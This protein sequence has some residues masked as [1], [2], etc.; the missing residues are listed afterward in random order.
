MTTAG[1]PHPLSQ[2]SEDD[3]VM[4]LTANGPVIRRIALTTAAA[5]AASGLAAIGAA[6]AAAATGPTTAADKALFAYAKCMR[7][8]GVK[9]PDP[10]KGKDGKFA[11]PAI[12]KSITDAAGVRAKAQA[13]A[14]TAG[15]LGNRSNGAANG[16][17]P[18]G[19]RGGF[20]GQQTPAQQAALKKFQDCLKANGATTALPGPGRRPPRAGTTTGAR[21]A[22]PATAKPS[23]TTTKGGKIAEPAIAGNGPGGGGRGPGGGGPGGAL[24]GGDAKTQAAFQ[25]CRALLLARPATAR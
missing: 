7:D 9:I 8:R 18:A 2:D 4:Q 12:S 16:D 11:F 22:A 5:L 3:D 25:K 10:A 23:A 17:G 14:A 1:V 20:G 15:A 13:C 6:A 19:G 21:A 24:R